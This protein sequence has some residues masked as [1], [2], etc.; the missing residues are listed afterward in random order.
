VH[1]LAASADGSHMPQVFRMR[2]NKHL[3]CFA[4]A[5][6]AFRETE[7][8]TCD[9]ASF[10]MSTEAHGTLDQTQTASFYA[11]ADGEQVIF[12]ID[13]QKPAG[14]VV[15]SSAMPSAINAPVTE[16]VSAEKPTA[17][18]RP[19]DE[20]QL[21]EPKQKKSK[22]LSWRTTNGKVRG[23]RPKAAAAKKGCKKPAGRTGVKAKVKN[24]SSKAKASP[25]KGTKRNP[26]KKVSH[27]AMPENM[28]SSPKVTTKSQRSVTVQTG[29]AKGWKV[30]AWLQEV[31]GQKARYYNNGIKWRISSPG[32]T[33]TFDT[34]RSTRGTPNLQDAV[35]VAVFTH[36]ST[37][38]KPEIARKIKQARLVIE[39]LATPEKKRE[40]SP[41]SEVKQVKRESLAPPL[42]LAPECK[43]MSTSLV[44]VSLAPPQL[45]PPPESLATQLFMQPVVPSPK[46]RPACWSCE[47][48][49]HLRRHPRCL[50]ASEQQ[51]PL[52]HLK[53][54]MLIGRG[55]SCDV[56]LGSRLT[57]QMISRCHAVL[58]Q[59]DGSFKLTDQGSL[60]GILVNGDSARSKTT[61][62]DGDVITFGVPTLQ[63]EFDYIF[64]VRS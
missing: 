25:K 19:R 23:A 12:E 20:Q 13:V 34:F 41:T 48:S 51:P 4:K 2:C 30:T 52:V 24:A 15:P 55:Q 35:D 1:L 39:G 16:I 22:T 38:V 21:S 37:A 63:P 29:P 43:D 33:R 14:Q 40:R 10:R 3:S 18:L 50:S 47:C 31:H 6:A 26:W 28:S 60:N 27:T 59:E 36:I 32:R 62:K 17:E 49:A 58:Q 57:P 5:Y 7:F 53:D 9:A 61:L 56:M 64:E 11:L 44:P 45:P 46:K 54:Y 8:G 42:Q